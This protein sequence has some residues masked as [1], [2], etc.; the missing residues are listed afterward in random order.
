M[1]E[2]YWG[3]KFNYEFHDEQLHIS[4]ATEYIKDVLRY[5]IGEFHLDGIRFIH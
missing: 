2:N 4:R 5:W 1:D 3:P